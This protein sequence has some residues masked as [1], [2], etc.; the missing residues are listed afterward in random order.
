MLL[1]KALAYLCGYNGGLHAILKLLG[2]TFISAG[3]CC[4]RCLGRSKTTKL[5]CAILPS[6]IT[7]TVLF[8]KECVATDCCSKSLRRSDTAKLFCDTLSSLIT[9]T[10]LFGQDGVA[11]WCCFSKSLKRSN[12]VKLCI[13]ILPPLMIE[14]RL[15]GQCCIKNGIGFLG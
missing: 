1:S 7:E 13:G 8:G 11:A 15:S 3:C 2:Q 6:L 14:T 4:S 10:G 9:D 5:F 12:T